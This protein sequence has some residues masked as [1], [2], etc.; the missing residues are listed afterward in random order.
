VGTLSALVARSDLE[1]PHLRLGPSL[2]PLLPE[3]APLARRL[4]GPGPAQEDAEEYDH[5]QQEEEQ[6]QLADE[7][8]Q[9]EYDRDAEEQADERDQ[10]AQ[11][12]VTPSVPEPA[13]VVPLDVADPPS[14][15]Q[16]SSSDTPVRP[17]GSITFMQAPPGCSGPA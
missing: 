5:G 11:W 7:Q 14:P 9:R 15:G 16:P 1:D 12:V 4:H 2:D 10:E 8:Q 6:D 13:R 3:Q 17:S